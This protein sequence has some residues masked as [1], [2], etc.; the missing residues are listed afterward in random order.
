LRPTASSSCR[1]I[2]GAKVL[3]AAVLTGMGWLGVVREKVLG[4][5]EQAL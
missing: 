1:R 2:A 5:L 4:E 3:R